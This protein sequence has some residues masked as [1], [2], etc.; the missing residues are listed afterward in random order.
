MVAILIKNSTH[1]YISSGDGYSRRFG[2]IV[3]HIHNKT[4]C[5]GDTLLWANN[6][7]ESFFQAVEWLYI[8]GHNG[9]ILN[10]DKLVFGAETIEFAGFEIT[11]TNV[12]PCNYCHFP[13]P[14]NITDVHSWSGPPKPSVICLCCN[15]GHTTLLPVTQTWHTLQMVGMSQLSGA[16][17]PTLPNHAVPQWKGRPPLFLM[18]SIKPDFLHWA[19]VTWSLL[20]I[21]N[22][23][24]NYPVV[25]PSRRSQTPGFVTSRRK[26]C[27]T[28]PEWCTSLAYNTKLWMQSLSTL[29]ILHIQTW[30]FYQMTLQPQVLQPS[31]PC[32]LLP[33]WNLLQRASSILHYFVLIPEH[34]GRFLGPHQSGHSK[35]QQHGTA[36]LYQ[37]RLVNTYF[38][39]LN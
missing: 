8:C 1:G 15:R 20:L 31:H 28:N 11:P 27:A 39:F 14:T 13:N 16:A 25:D 9:I 32:L 38:V 12:Q 35:W 18:P 37:S 24:L 23:Y 10:P 4:K 7:T 33:D 3:S 21:T 17:S 36:R 6:L 34:C 22:L 29:L 26:P 30:C 5:I 19:A 2:E